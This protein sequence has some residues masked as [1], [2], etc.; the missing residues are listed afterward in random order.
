MLK[1][2][3][4]LVIEDNENNMELITF[5]LT[6]KGYSV[7][8]AYSG[9]DGLSK[10]DQPEIDFVL[11]DIQ[12]PDIDGLEVLR[13]IKATTSSLPVI[14]MTSF[15]MTGDRER[16]LSAGCTGYIEK[17]IEAETVVEQ[18]ETILETQS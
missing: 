5:I 9:L 8:S 7:D 13:R 1:P 3:K 4:A 17:P 2:R 12:L 16:M 18:I 15:A 11:L 6:A 10:V 14:A